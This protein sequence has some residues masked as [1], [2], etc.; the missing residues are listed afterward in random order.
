MHLPALKH[1]RQTAH[2]ATCWLLCSMDWNVT[3]LKHSLDVSVQQTSL[4]RTSALDEE[5]NDGSANGR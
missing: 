5:I 2:S 1:T 3:P 4:L